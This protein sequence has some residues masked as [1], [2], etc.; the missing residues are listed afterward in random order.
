MALGSGG[1][2]AWEWNAGS[3]SIEWDG[4]LARLLS[5]S[6]D[7]PPSRTKDLL[8][9]IEAGDRGRLLQAARN[10]L[11][12]GHPIAID[13]RVRRFDGHEGWLAVRGTAIKDEHQRPSGL[14]G[15]VH[16]ITEQ[17]Q[18]LSRTDALLREVSHRSKNILALILAMAR[19]TA[20]DTVDVK[21][22]LKE[23]ALRVAGLAASQDLIVA[24]DWQSVDLGA[25]AVAQIDAVAR[26][27]ATRVKIS[28]PSFAVTPESAQTVG[29]IL[30]E[31]TLNALQHGALS[32]AHGEVRLTWAF[33]DDT[34][35]MI[36]WQEVGGPGYDPE[37]PPGY[38]MSVVERF[39]TQGLKATAH[40]SGDA[41]G[42]LWVLN[43]PVASLG[44]RLPPHRA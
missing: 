17:K 42:F 22:H 44:A 1:V 36:S 10:A 14:V 37:R 19:L 30:T 16:D 3:D 15:I 9:R 4:T 35:I 11:T 33:P 24:S 12:R 40:A 41:S 25:L 26:T 32:L 29:M 27:D 28:G 13:I 7:A 21:S 6:P 18:S 8:K 39:S 20:R 34:T 38:G 5:A 23:F 43:A 31:L 2:G